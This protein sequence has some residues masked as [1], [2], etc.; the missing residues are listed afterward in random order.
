MADLMYPHPEV[1]LYPGHLAMYLL[2]QQRD[3]LESF[4]A[5][6]GAWLD[7]REVPEPDRDLFL[8]L[9]FAGLV[10]AG[11]H[12]ILVLTVQKIVEFVERA[13]PAGP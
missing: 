10:A 5:D 11:Y 7:R 2:G 13:R 9:D 1:P 4:L 12:P 3:E 6:R 8:R